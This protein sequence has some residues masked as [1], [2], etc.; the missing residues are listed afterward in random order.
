[1][2]ED[3]K[4]GA[5]GTYGEEEEFMCATEREISR[6]AFTEQTQ[7]YNINWILKKQNFSV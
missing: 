6:N 1:V 2:G 3:E 7:S 4:G 5:C